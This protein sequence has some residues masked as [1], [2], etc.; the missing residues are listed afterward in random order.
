MSNVICYF[1]FIINKDGKSLNPD[2]VQNLLK[3]NV[4]E[5][6]TQLNLFKGC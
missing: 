5:N 4:P 6:V 2:K 1:R 3:A